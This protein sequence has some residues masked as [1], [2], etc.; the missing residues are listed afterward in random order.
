MGDEIQQ[1]DLNDAASK[2]RDKIKLG[3]AELIPDEQWEQMIRA[4][5]VKFTEPKPILDYYKKKTGESPSE[6]SVIC[7]ELLHE[8]VK[9]QVRARIQTDD[10]FPDG[11]QLWELLQAWLD[12]NYPKVLQELATGIMGGLV[13]AAIGNAV[14]AV[15]IMMP[16]PDPN[17]P[18]YDMAGRPMRT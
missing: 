9:E 1:M 15:S 13:T 3:F 8:H 10:Y 7:R 12:V 17:N 5:V 18:G 16:I 14:N 6:F 4:E 2:L 11:K